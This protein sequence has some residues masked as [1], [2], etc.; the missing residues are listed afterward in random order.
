MPSTTLGKRNSGHPDV[1]TDEESDGRYADAQALLQRHFEARFR[2]LPTAARATTRPGKDAGVGPTRHGQRG[3]G[4]SNDNDTDHAATDS[5][6]E[7]SEWG[8]VSSDDGEHG[9]EDDRDEDGP[10]SRVEVVDHASSQPVVTSTMTK[11]ELKAYLVRW[12]G[13]R[14]PPSYVQGVQW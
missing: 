13:A 7:P 3:R 14:C 12:R 10:G 2:P 1:G 6:S 5:D 9:D 4:D 11:R 8:G